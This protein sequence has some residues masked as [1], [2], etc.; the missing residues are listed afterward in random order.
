MKLR[1]GTRGS[2][3]ALVQTRTI[4]R[5]LAKDFPDLEIEEVVVRTLGDKVADKPLFK[6]GGQG[7]FIKEIEEALQLGKIDVAVHSLKDMPHSLGEGLALA[8]VTPR[9][10][11]RDVLISRHFKK[12]SELPDDCAIGTSSLRRRVQ[13]KTLRPNLRFCDLRGNLDTR[14]RK[15]ETGDM[16]AVV[17]A[18]AGL[19]RLGLRAKIAE[20]FP[21]EILIPAA[22]QGFLGLECRKEDLER[23]G[24]LFETIGNSRAWAMAT[25]ERAFLQKLQG[26]CRLPIAAHC[27]EQN[28]LLFLTGFIADPEGKTLLRA[29]FSG[30]D[31]DALGAKTAN[32]LLAK[33]AEKII[34]EWRKKEMSKENT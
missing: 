27:C 25:A 26:G 24:E 21:V 5:M 4:T 9:E 18:A 20:F 6:F 23:F 2:Q 17:L 7:V 34:G 22:G 15:L 33:G 12:L 29:A 13:L 10:D 1:F 11:P 32:E 14:L 16:D 31:P 19:N 30:S 3:L 8:A 28:G